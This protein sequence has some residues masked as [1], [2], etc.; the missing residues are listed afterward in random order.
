MILGGSSW[1]GAT[2]L[3]A[4]LAFGCGGSDEDVIN[5]GGE[6]S[7][8]SPATGGA[9]SVAPAGGGGADVGGSGG[10]AG[11][12]GGAG[13]MGGVAVTDDLGVGDGQDV[14][15]IGDSYMNLV[16]LGVMQSLDA[17][18]GQ[19]YRKHAVPGTRMLDDAIPN[20]YRDA[21]GQNP[22]IAT[23]VMDG[24]GNDILGGPLDDCRNG[25]G[26]DCQATLDQVFEAY[27]VFFQELADDGVEDVV[28]F[29][30]PHLPR[31][32]AD[33]A[34]TLDDGAARAAAECENSPVDCHFIDTI[35]AFTGNEE[36]YN[37][38]DDIHPNQT[39]MDVI[40][41]LVWDAMV[42]GGVRR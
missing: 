19:S 22:N 6:S 30:Y 18:S 42:E 2:L 35:P 26:P 4:A 9:A 7:G 36:A 13:G 37:I 41:S 33:L 11:G 31:T 24:G 14:V 40:A 8:G 27:G 28:V 25:P 38:G 5:V 29:S 39:G 3:V 1:R 21:R 17:I 34:E 10:V 20:Q 12:A 32:N 23:V 16:V 15:V